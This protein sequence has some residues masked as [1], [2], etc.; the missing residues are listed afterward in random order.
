MV[1]HPRE[2]ASDL[3]G[4]GDANKSVIE[5]A[6]CGQRRRLNNFNSGLSPGP[7]SIRGAYV[8]MGYEVNKKPYP[9]CVTVVTACES[10]E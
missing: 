6:M 4:D 2:S 10:V 3:K 5:A 7:Y 9:S 8:S 1:A